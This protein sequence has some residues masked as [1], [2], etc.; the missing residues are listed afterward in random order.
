[1]QM[2]IIKQSKQRV[3]AITVVLW[4]IIT[5]LGAYLYA[6]IQMRTPTEEPVFV[7]MWG[8]HLWMYAIYVLPISFIILAVILWLESRLLS[9][10]KAPSD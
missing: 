3:I 5:I 10:G 1:M 6:L 4:A 8:W 9:S 7:S 2:Q